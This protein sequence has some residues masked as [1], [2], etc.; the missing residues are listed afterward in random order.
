MNDILYI[1]PEH[2]S[3]SIDFS[4]ISAIFFS[5]FLSQSQNSLIFLPEV[6]FTYKYIEANSLAVQIYDMAPSS[7]CF[8]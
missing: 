2:V 7:P 8:S 6:F 4:C 1:T 5:E 3:E